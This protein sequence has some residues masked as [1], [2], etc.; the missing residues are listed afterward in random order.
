MIQQAE[1]TNI[2]SLSQP[3][4]RT[5]K[6]YVADNPAFT[7][8]AIDWLIFHKREKLLAAQAIAYF[9][10]KILIIPPNFNLFILNGET[11]QIGGYANA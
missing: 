7:I 1:T 4:F 2:P 10:S 9:G 5:K 11:R 3:Y 8:G 6:Q